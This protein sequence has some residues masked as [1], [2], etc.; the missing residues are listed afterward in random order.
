MNI[1]IK[2]SDE[3]GRITSLS[4]Q[5]KEFIHIESPLFKL[6]LMDE[7]G[8]F[9]LLTSDEFEHDFSL[10]SNQR[11]MNFENK[12]YNINVCA[13]VTNTSDDTLTWGFNVDNNS[14]YYIDRIYYPCSTLP[15][16]LAGE[17]GTAKLML[18]CFEGEE[19]SKLFDE[20]G[21]EKTYPGFLNMQFAA[22]YDTNAGLYAAMEDTTGIPKNIDFIKNKD[23]GID[24]VLGEYPAIYPNTRYEIP[25]PI[26]T[27][28]F[29]GAWEECCDFYREFIETSG[30]VL[31][32]K[33]KDNPRLPSWHKDSAV[34]TICPVRSIVGVDYF[35][36][37]EYQPY[38]NGLKYMLELSE[39]FDVPVMALLIG[40][41]GTAP[42]APPLMW[43]PYGGEEELKR[44]VDEM[45]KHGQYV[46]LYGSGINWTEQSHF[47][48]E[49]NF[50]DYRLK[51]GIDDILCRL[52]NG[53]LSPEKV[54]VEVRTGY[55]MCPV[56]KGT[57]DMTLD[58]INGIL[59]ADIDYLQYFDQNLGARPD[60]C[61]AKDHGHPPLHG[62]WST[63]A[64]QDLY[65]SIDDMIEEKGSDC[66]LGAECAP[67]DYFLEHLPFNDH[68][69]IW[70]MSQYSF[71]GARKV[72]CVPAFQY[73]FHEYCVNFMGNQCMFTGMYPNDLNPD[74]HMM[75][76]AYGFISGDLL[77]VVL[78]SGGEIH[79]NWGS[80][81]TEPG[82]RQKPVK[83]FIKNLSDMRKNAGNKYLH[84]GKMIKADKLYDVPDYTLVTKEGEK[85]VYPSVMS[86]KWLAPDGEIAQILVN[87]TDT[88]KTVT[89]SGDYT[90]IFDCDGVET[91]LSDDKKI[92]IKP[93][94]A[95][96]VK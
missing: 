81:W 50:T 42:W 56:C 91:S 2:F 57:K 74:S 87:F 79:Y 43:P 67:S 9:T 16:D 63:D 68:R 36:P 13:S 94:T 4:S 90:V 95:I 22:Y 7:K 35:G 37:N 45:H 72:R 51:H 54:V 41:E 29:V 30:F 3:N 64:M 20:A 82:P 18:P 60:L 40:W 89:I 75:C 1:N 86:S 11:K 84:F 52:P 34:V 59:S 25:Y 28:A 58:Q 15:N 71:T 48:K 44:Y 53:E 76:L 55:H 70:A 77:T 27:R 65:K 6:K 12:K 80:K 39:D 26:I 92:T 46:G 19:I 83:K 96:G 10:E 17:G 32:P 23:G 38:M 73:V 78:K 5:D 69:F 8:E 88:E 33:V 31:P 85:V 47:V 49:C 14:Q 66:I 61:Y 62:K 21:D 24:L 93:Y